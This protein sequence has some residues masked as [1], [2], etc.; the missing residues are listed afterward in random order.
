MSTISLTAFF[1]E[2]G[3]PKTG[4]S[5]TVT[6]WD[7]ADSSV[8]VNGEAMTEI[9]GG[10][11][12]YEW[13]SFDLT[14][15]YVARADGGAGQPTGERYA[16]IDMST[17]ALSGKIDAIDNDVLA[18]IV[19]GTLTVKQVLAVILAAVANKADGGGSTEVKFT[20]V[21]D[22]V[23]RIFMTVNDAGDRASVVL[24]VSDL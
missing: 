9:A 10:W 2:A 8:D 17:A 12:K 14:K 22:S 21:A 11:Y 6:A 16:P 19:E 23:N 24:D 18:S 13:S 4:L 20:N 3:V 15:D 1:T 5:P 7:V